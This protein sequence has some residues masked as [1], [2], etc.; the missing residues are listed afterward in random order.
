MHPNA[1]N[2]HTPNLYRGYLGEVGRQ[3]AEKQ[4]L[5]TLKVLHDA[6]TRYDNPTFSSV[7]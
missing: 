5:I 3:V 2:E 7:P 6:N 1:Q 4:C